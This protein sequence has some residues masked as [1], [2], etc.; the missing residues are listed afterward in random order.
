MERTK[1]KHQLEWE[2]AI[3]LMSRDELNFAIEHPEG[4]YPTFLKMAKA[5]LEELSTLPEH[6]AMKAVVI[7][8][9]EDMGCSCTIDEDGCINFYFQGSK[10]F[11]SLEEGNHY[12]DICEYAWDTADLNDANEVERLKHSINVAN[13]QCTVTTAYEIDE[14][15]RKLCVFC[16][17]S[18]L[19]RPM[20]INLKDY[21]QIRLN[22]FFLAHDIVHAEMVLL[23][24]REERSMIDSYHVSNDN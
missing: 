9:L 7:N 6:E 2:K 13:K 22:N 12:I 19:Y 21:L 17:T 15:I 5:K 8:I 1:T 10:F 20:V 18:I 14:E 11:M 16:S 4:Y 23:K 24:E 3:N